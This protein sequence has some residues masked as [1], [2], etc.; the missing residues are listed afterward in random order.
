MKKLLLT[1]TFISFSLFSFGEKNE[2]LGSLL[3]E[4]A[5]INK[6]TKKNKTLSEENR[7]RLS[8]IHPM[9]TKR[10]WNEFEAAINKA[11]K[12]DIEDILSLGALA[13]RTPFAWKTF[14]SNYASKSEKKSLRGLG[15]KKH[16]NALRI[17]RMMRT[18]ARRCV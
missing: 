14:E 18:G 2:T 15:S 1:T 6:V 12:M 8:Q 13:A 16:P 11:D 3:D 10:P 7:N 4:V 17:V 9:L 5:H